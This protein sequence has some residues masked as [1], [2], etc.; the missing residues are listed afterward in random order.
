MSAAPAS[1]YVGTSDGRIVIL[2]GQGAGGRN[3][4]LIDP[5]WIVETRAHTDFSDGLDQWSVYKHH[6]PAQRWWRA[7]AVG[8][9]LIANPTDPADRSLHIRKPD[10]LPADGAVWNFPNGWKG[11]LTARVMVRP[12]FQG[13]LICLNDR[14]FDPTNDWGDEFAV[15]RTALTPD[16]RV[17]M[18]TLEPDRWHDLTLAWNLD[19]P[20][21][22]L[23]VDGEEAGRLDLRHQTLNGISYVQFRSTAT[24]TDPAGFLLDRVTVNITDPYAPPCSREDQLAHERRY[25][26]QVV[27]LWTEECSP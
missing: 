22:R 8:C 2:A 15:F 16:A 23:M 6:G 19:L 20:E 26:E 9:E 14:M 25:V 17:G 13:G 1:T 4:I 5:R 7:R 21:C 10:D 12:G 11:T 18:A 27:P 24:G 3:P